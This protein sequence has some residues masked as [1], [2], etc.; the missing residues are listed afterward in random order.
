M[1]SS[2]NAGYEDLRVWQNSIAFA[3]KI[4]LLTK[5]FPK[6][7][8]YSLTT[9]LQKSAVSIASNIAEGCA[10]NTHQEFI[11]FLGIASG[12]LA[13]YVTQ[14]IIAHEIGFVSQDEF[15]PIRAEGESVGKMLS[16]LKRSIRT[17]KSV[18]KFPEPVTSNQ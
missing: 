9:Q 10:R 1:G 4:Y 16:A 7:Q 8:Q 3:K 13:E 15:Y 17:V 18:S 11:H 2:S 6:D 14:L 12:S 5:N